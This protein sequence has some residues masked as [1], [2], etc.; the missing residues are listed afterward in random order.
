MQTKMIW[1]KVLMTLLAVLTSVGGWADSSGSCGSGV[2][3]SYDNGTKTLTISGT[4]A[5]DSYYKNG[6]AVNM[7]WYDYRS[8]ITT[9]VIEDGVTNIGDAAFYTYYTALA[10][11][12]IPNSVTSIGDYAFYDCDALQNITIPASMTI[13]GEEAFHSCTGIRD[14]HCQSATPPSLYASSFYPEIESATLYV[15]K[16]TIKAYKKNLAWGE[17]VNIAEE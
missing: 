15:P 1:A 12:T 17:F 5:M 11:V 8:N 2:T 16:G 10:S 6:T 4:G 13:I 3:W 14:I 9:V 7:P